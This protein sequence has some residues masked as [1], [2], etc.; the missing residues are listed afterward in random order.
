MRFDLQAY[1]PDALLQSVRE[2]DLTSLTAV[3]AMLDAQAHGLTFAQFFRSGAIPIQQFLQFKNAWE[4]MLC[5]RTERMGRE[6]HTLR[7]D[8]ATGEL[9][10]PSE[11][12]TGLV[13][14]SRLFSDDSDQSDPDQPTA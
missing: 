13:E 10:E 12:T 11:S 7:L 2:I 5:D 3:K 14:P 9:L 8:E 1:N 4:L 6:T